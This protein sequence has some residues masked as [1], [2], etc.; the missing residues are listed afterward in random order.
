MYPDGFLCINALYNNM[1][2]FLF[3]SMIRRPPRSTRADTL[4]PCTTLFRSATRWSMP[5]SATAHRHG[6]WRCSP[7]TCSTR[8]IWRTRSEEHTSE[9]QSLM[10]ISYAVFCLKKNTNTPTLRKY[11][12]NP[13]STPTNNNTMPPVNHQETDHVHIQHTKTN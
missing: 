3:F 7:A 10:R 13:Y 2:F 11:L 12:T 9:L 1:R 4:F 5:A 8:I 6:K